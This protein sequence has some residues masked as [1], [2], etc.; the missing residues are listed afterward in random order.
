MTA[1]QVAG[2]ELRRLPRMIGSAAGILLYLLVLGAFG[3][4]VPARWGFEFLNPM[5]LAAYGAMAGLFASPVSV[6]ACFGVR[7]FPHPART[8]LIGKIAFVAAYGWVSATLILIVGLITVNIRNWHG[9]PLLPPAIFLASLFAFSLSIAVF[10]TSMGA[11][12]AVRAPSTRSAKRIMRT[13][14]LVFL[15]FLVMFVRYAPDEWRF[16]MTM[17]LSQERFPLFVLLTGLHLWFFAIMLTRAA[18]GR[19]DEVLARTER[20]LGLE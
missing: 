13:A 12:L 14:F 11:A 17:Q 18:L 6:E 7:D 19:V 16:R 15:L 2:T 10:V 20:P 5:V 9:Q 8:A 1:S 3:L 4:M